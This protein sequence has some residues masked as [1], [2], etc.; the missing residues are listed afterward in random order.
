MTELIHLKRVN[1][2]SVRMRTSCRFISHK[3]LTVEIYCE[4]KINAYGIV[5]DTY[6]SSFER[7]FVNKK[8]NYDRRTSLLLLL[9]SFC[10]M[11]L[12]FKLTSVLS[13]TFACLQLLQKYP[14]V[15]YN[16]PHCHT[17]RVRMEDRKSHR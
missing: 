14:E 5:V 13:K 2:N 1:G 8:G 7:R 3:Y 11:N 16:V 6:S 15:N 17:E 12:V 9:N 4:E 10:K